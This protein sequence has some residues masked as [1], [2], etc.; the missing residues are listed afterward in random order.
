MPTARVCVYVCLC[1]CVCVV[2]V[3]TVQHWL[4]TLVL[5]VVRH[6][7][8]TWERLSGSQPVPRLWETFSVFIIT[9]DRVV[10]LGPR[11]RYF[12]H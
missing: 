2:N 1:V 9:G 5:Q 7:M 4:W 10:Q 3:A 8:F 11:D 12:L 6:V